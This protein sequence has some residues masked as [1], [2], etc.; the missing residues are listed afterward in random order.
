MKFL[1][2]LIASLLFVLISTTAFAVT[3][4]EVFA[5]AEANFPSIFAG[6]PTAGQIAYQGTQYD[7]RYYPSSGNYL[8]VDSSG[9]ISI[10]GPYT[11]GMLTPIGPVTAYANTINA[12]E[13]A[14]IPYTVT[15]HAVSDSCSLPNDRV[16]SGVLTPNGQANAYT[17]LFIA[18]T[19]ITLTVPGSNTL[20]FSYPDGSSLDRNGTTIFYTTT[21]HMQL[22][23]DSQTRLIT[24]STNWTNTDGCVGSMTFS[25]SLGSAGQSTVSQFNGA[26][27]GTYRSSATLSPFTATVADGVVT[28]TIS[29]GTGGVGV[30]SGMVSA[31]GVGALTNFS[32]FACP[33]T[34]GSLQ[35]TI[36]ATGGAVMSA[37]SY[38][39]LD[40]NDGPS[41]AW[42]ATRS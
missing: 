39:P 1:N 6:G 21:E 26:Y 42:T 2:K 4:A 36:T 5:F 35:I 16:V 15:A 40:C 25:G 27:T 8:A 33:P 28:I 10:L 11:G 38:S 12:W 22:T 3:D 19:A 17:T 29:N 24:G 37:T 20:V 9:V 13:G 34:S 23:F 30:V 18:N 31:S 41:G 7:Y 14:L 32:G